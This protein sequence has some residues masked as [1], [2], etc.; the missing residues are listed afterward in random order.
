MSLDLWLYFGLCYNKVSLSAVFFQL[1]FHET[2]DIS[3]LV[4]QGYS[5][6][7]SGQQED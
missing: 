6:M 7:S 1:H 4:F 2:F 5:F 3:S